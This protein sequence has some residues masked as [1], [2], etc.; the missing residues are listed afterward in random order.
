MGHF[1]KNHNH[2]V[3]EYACIWFYFL[4]VLMYLNAIYMHICPLHKVDTKFT[5]VLKL[6]FKS[7]TGLLPTPQ[8]ARMLINKSRAQIRWQVLFWIMILAIIMDMKNLK[9]INT[10]EAFPST[11]RSHPI[12]QNSGDLPLRAYSH[13][14][15][16]LINNATKHDQRYKI[17]LF[18]AIRAIRSLKLNRKKVKNKQCNIMQT[19]VNLCNLIQITRLQAP[20]D[21]RIKIA[22]VN[23]QSIRHK[24]LQVSE[25]ISNHN[26]DFVVIT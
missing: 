13:D 3:K 26:L 7:L 12:L 2:L 1:M 22:T 24:D 4:R 17:V 6:N 25:L 23:T 14:E 18:R 15:L 5:L 20:Q 10:T 21:C 11:L 9:F 19:G 8:K 16:V